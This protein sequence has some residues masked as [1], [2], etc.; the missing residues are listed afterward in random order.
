MKNL[1]LL[2]VL[3]LLFTACVNKSKVTGEVVLLNPAGNVKLPAMPVYFF[4]KSRTAEFE[5]R[6][7]MPPYETLQ[8]DGEAVTDENGKFTLYLPK[9]EYTIY[10]KAEVTIEGKPQSYG[11][12]ILSTVTDGENKVRLASYMN[13]GLNKK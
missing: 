12:L 10:A 8:P 3:C 9:G 13:M 1:K 4:A 11:W 2:L 5:S 6:R 7:E